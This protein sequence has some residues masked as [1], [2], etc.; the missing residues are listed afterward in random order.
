MRFVCPT[1]VWICIS[2]TMLLVCVS[3]PS[4]AVT[5][6]EDDPC[7]KLKTPK[8]IHEGY[9]VKAQYKPTFPCLV[10]VVETGNY[11]KSSTVWNDYILPVVDHYFANNLHKDTDYKLEPLLWKI[12]AGAGSEGAARA[13]KGFTWSERNK[14]AVS[15]QLNRF[16][17]PK[18]ITTN[19]K[20][21]TITKQQ[22]AV[23]TATY[24]NSENIQLTSLSPNFS[25]EVKPKGSG[26]ARSEGSKIVV[27]AL[28]GGNQSG[29]LII[30][31]KKH[32]LT[33][34]VPLVF[35][36]RMSILWPLGGL[37]VTGGAAAWAASTDDD[38]T[39]TVLWIVTGVS[40]VVTSVLIYR[41][42]RG[43]GVPFLSKSDDGR[44][45]EALAVRFEPGPRSMA[46]KVKF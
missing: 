8:L 41:Y 38:G 2:M 9:L 19:P 34:A 5:Q 20:K 11:K 37:A 27:S 30:S 31:D 36:G 1:R 29:T 7:D 16:Y 4:G 46:I 26:T 24:I 21:A 15:N 12:M 44:S 10:K 32:G 40:A 25:I 43:K 42:F 3:S 22:E 45:D 14:S 6:Q 28:K 35:S 18:G 17:K 39:S 13:V 33:T 23:F